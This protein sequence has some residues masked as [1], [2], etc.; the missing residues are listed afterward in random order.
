MKFTYVTARHNFTAKLITLL[1]CFPWVF[2]DFCVLRFIQIS[3]GQSLNSFIICEWLNHG[4]TN[5]YAI[6]LTNLFPKW[7]NDVLSIFLP[8]MLF[9]YCTR[10]FYLRKSTFSSAYI[11]KLLFFTICT[12][13][14]CFPSFQ[15]FGCCNTYKKILIKWTDIHFLIS[16]VPKSFVGSDS[17]WWLQ[18]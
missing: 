5:R 10:T 9:C 8:T 15:Y 17:Y 11:Q 4:W 1:R 14:F 3:T 18:C 2:P 16:G 6:Q 13:A 12:Y 7:I